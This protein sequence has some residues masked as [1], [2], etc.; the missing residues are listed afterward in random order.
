MLAQTEPSLELL[1]VGDGCTDNT[2]EVIEPY[3]S[4]PRVQWFDYPKAPGFGYANRNK[5]LRRARGLY[6]AFL[7]HD[8]IYFNDHLEILGRHLDQNPQIDLVY[9]RPLWVDRNGDIFPSPWNLNDPSMYDYFMQERNEIP[10]LCFIYRATLHQQLGYWNEQIEKA[11]DWELWKRFLGARPQANFHFEPQP[12]GLHFKAS[13]KT[14]PKVV[15]SR[16]WELVKFFR[17]GDVLPAE[18]Q[19]D[20][21]PQ[22]TEQEQF[23]RLISNA[24]KDFC[25]TIRRAVVQLLDSLCQIHFP[26]ALEKAAKYKR[27]KNAF[28]EHAK[29]LKRSIE[30]ST[31]RQAEQTSSD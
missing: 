7:G 25:P 6:I 18:L 1:V 24:N 16:L 22:C 21:P 20:V 27:E 2:A 31:I 13:W 19:V 5:V 10:A 26:S 30:A 28:A 9:S 15:P 14:G 29:K 17:E 4:D 8:D 11:G 23:W 3:L 12:T